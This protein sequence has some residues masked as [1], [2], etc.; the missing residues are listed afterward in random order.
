VRAPRAAPW[1]GAGCPARLS[2][3]ETQLGHGGLP[4]AVEEAEQSTIPAK[5]KGTEPA[6]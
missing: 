3:C 4:P 2:G 6:A 1:A 5:T